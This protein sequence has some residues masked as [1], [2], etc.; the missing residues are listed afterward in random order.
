MGRHPEAPVV[1]AAFIVQHLL[2]ELVDVAQ[3]D[4]VTVEG[5]DGA[6][7]RE[8]EQAQLVPAD[9]ERRP[10]CSCV[11]GDVWSMPP[12]RGNAQ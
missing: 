7:L 4:E 9:A 5:D 1:L 10:H 2:N 3:H 12:F 6:V 8:E 11:G